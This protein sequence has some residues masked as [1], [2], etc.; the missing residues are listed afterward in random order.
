MKESATSITLPAY[1]SSWQ[2]RNALAS[3]SRGVLLEWTRRGWIRSL[4]TS[5]AKQAGR[6]FSTADVQDVL[7]RMS[8]GKLPAMRVRR[9]IQKQDTITGGD[10]DGN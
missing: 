6:L 4:K 1:A 2:I 5:A 9:A 7:D 10:S 8:I 3:V